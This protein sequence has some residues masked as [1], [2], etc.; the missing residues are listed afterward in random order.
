MAASL[1]RFMRDRSGLHWTKATK[2]TLLCM[3]SCRLYVGEVRAPFGQ[4]AKFWLLRD[5]R[6]STTPGGKL[7]VGRDPNGTWQLRQRPQTRQNAQAHAELF[8]KFGSYMLQ[9][10]PV[11]CCSR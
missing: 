2:H 6:H 10:H 4:L 5:L 11:A 3:T 9:L 8:L 1:S 7:A